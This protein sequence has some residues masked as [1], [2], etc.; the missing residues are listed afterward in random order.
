MTDI[1]AEPI[2][3]QP[4]AIALTVLD[5]C[6]NVL[7]ALR[8]PAA[9]AELEQSAPDEAF[10]TRVTEMLSRPSDLSNLK[11]S[12]IHYRGENGFVLWD[13]L[14]RGFNR[15]SKQL[16]TEEK[17]ERIRTL[18][19]D[20][21]MKVLEFAKKMDDPI[22]SGRS[23]HEPLSLVESARPF[24]VAKVC[25]WLR[26]MGMLEQNDEVCYSKPECNDP[27]NAEA[28]LGISSGTISKI[29]SW[30]ESEDSPP[31]K[32]L[33]FR[34][35]RNDG[36][37]ELIRHI[38]LVQG[39]QGSVK[40]VAGLLNVI[41]FWNETR[42][43]AFQKHVITRWGKWI[44]YGW[45]S[46][47]VRTESQ[48]ANTARWIEVLG[49]IE[50]GSGK[51]LPTNTVRTPP[52]ITPLFLVKTPRGLFDELTHYVIGQDDAKRQ[53]ATLV[54]YQTIL[55]MREGSDPGS[56][57]ASPSPLLLAGPTGCGK[58]LL[59]ST[60]CRLTGLP[61]IRVDA[62]QMVPEGIVG[63]SI[64]DL[65]KQLIS[66][67]IDSE[68]TI[69]AVRHAVV[70]FDEIDKLNN[71]YYG[72]EVIHQLLTLLDGGSIPL[73]DSRGTWK[74]PASSLPC[75]DMVFI[76]GGAFQ[77]LFDRAGQAL[78]GFGCGTNV[79]QG[80]NSIGLDD[81]A[82]AGFPREFL[83]RIH[84]WEV[85]VPLSVEQLELI[86]TESKSS[87]LIAVNEMLSL[88][89]L[90][91]ELPKT[92]SQRIAVAANNSGY[93]ARALHQ[94]IQEIAEPWM[95][96]ASNHSGKCHRITVKET[97]AALARLETKGAFSL[98]ATK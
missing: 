52:C 45:P 29:M 74:P 84:R 82:R 28:F 4:E 66:D 54:H 7:V 5:S 15:H 19:R 65:G 93:G 33:P 42:F 11:R 38:L 59:V 86:L 26:Q 58:T 12:S 77:S 61:F 2:R 14:E 22:Q 88:H 36:T 85:M 37:N 17:L 87:P 39:T 30:L 44:G 94:I 41:S 6:C 98:A 27:Q 83:G 81:L 55:R 24:G 56:D 76:L 53:I 73:N 18:A 62:S 9:V 8:K 51:V 48:A 23:D 57:L 34:L 67:F 64:N 78:I 72:R 40:K 96:E 10:H 16:T 21:P 46:S 1:H 63:Y 68:G 20:T 50:K 89:R 70:F 32:L 92:A 31:A 91:L 71:S 90:Q 35:A 3:Y 13:D 60:A 79:R 95:F 43:T 97:E 69:E 49:E 47:D 80:T 75:K 25:G